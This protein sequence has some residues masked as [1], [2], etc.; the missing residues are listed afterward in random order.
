S[1]AQLSPLAASPRREAASEGRDHLSFSGLSAGLSLGGSGRSNQLPI[2][3]PL[4]STVQ[5]SGFAPLFFGPLGSYW[6]VL[7]QGSLRSSALIKGLSPLV[8]SSSDAGYFS[9]V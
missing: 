6:N 1:G 7:P 2:I 4:G 5:T 9:L 3:L 8:R